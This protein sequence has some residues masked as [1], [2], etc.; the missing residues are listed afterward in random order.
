MLELAYPWILLLTVLPLVWW[1]RKR[2]DADQV[3]APTLPVGHWLSDLPGVSRSGNARSVW[4]KLLL[5][6]AWLLLVVALAR[7]QY[8]GESVQLPV[9][10]RDLLLAVDISPSMEEEDMILGQRRVNRLTAVKS[11]L[12]DFIARRDGDRLGLLL[13]GTQP[14][15]QAPLSFDHETIRT[16]LQEAQLGMAGRATAIGDAIGLAVKRLRDRPQEQR[17]L[18]LLT[19][20]ANT[21]GEVTPEKAAEIAAAAGV[22]IYTIGMGAETM[23]QRGFLGSRK[24]NP[25]RDLDEE[26]LQGIADKTGG[27][28]FR[29]RSTPELEMIYE[30]INQ[31]EPIELEGKQYRPTT[32][33]FY[34]P[35]GL[36][37]MLMLAGMFLNHIKRR[38][39]E[40]SYG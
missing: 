12:N 28:Y 30:T 9:T 25:S 18:V 20:G 5:L 13:F 15:I 11:V 4:Q 38:M 6:L 10:G 17:V 2:K 3:A 34:W 33:L 36:A 19:D 1:G 27:Q 31:L 7:P 21:A 8:V 22:R 40:A 24:I 32:D 37:V 23:I 29:A 14:Y 16:L 39:P 26:L 35:A